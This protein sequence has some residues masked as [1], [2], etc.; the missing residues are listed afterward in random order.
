[1][2]AENSRAAF[3][4]GEALALYTGSMKETGHRA[5]VDELITCALK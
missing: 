5:P 1:M 4:L 2:R 3:L